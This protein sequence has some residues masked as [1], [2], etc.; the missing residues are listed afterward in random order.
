MPMRN[1]VSL[2]PR[3]PTDRSRRT[4]AA[5]AASVIAGVLLLAA[6]VP[7][8]GVGATAPSGADPTGAPTGAPRPSI[9][10]EQAVAH[11]NDKITFRAGPTVSVA[12]KPRSADHWTID[13]AAPLALPA[14]S[15]SGASIRDGQ[16]RL[17]SPAGS[18]PGTVPGRSSGPIDAP[19]VDP[20][21]SI[22]TRL[23]AVVDPG[24]LR[25]EVFGFLPYWELSDPSTTLDW[26][27]LS[28]IAYFGVGATGNGDLQQQNA[29]GSTTVGWSGWTSA[30]LT[31]VINTAHANGSRVVLTV[32]SFAWTSSQLGQQKALLGSSTA[33]ANLARQIAAAVRDRGADGVNLDFEPIAA[34]Y[35][36]E[37]TSLVQAIRGE[38]DAI[39]PGYQLTFDTMGWIGNYPIEAATAP[40]GAD[41]IVIMGYDYRT[42]S[43]GTAGSVSPLGGPNYDLNDTLAAYVQRVP[44]SKLILGVPYYG[45][46]WSTSSSALNATTVAAAKYGSSVAVLYE[47]A[48]DFST[49]YGRL[50]DPVE[51]AAWT[52]YQ[53][54]NCS[55]AYG[56]VAATRELYYDDAETLAAKYDLVNTYDI[57]GI[58]IWALGYDGSHPELY[59]VIKDKFITDTI[60]PAITGS[61][62][63]AAVF[64]PN[65]DGRQDSTTISVTVTGLIRYG[66]VV[67]PF[68]DSIA[69]APIVQGSAD[70]E[71]VAYTWDG[72][73]QDGT[74]APDGTYRVTVWTAD[75]S[76]NQ[77]SVQT[78]VT[79]DN[80]APVLTSTAKP[81][82][83]S[84]NG[85]GRSDAT[86]LGM[87]SSEPVSGVARILDKTRLVVRTWKFDPA[88]ASSWVW[89]GKD[90]AGKTVR[91][92]VY[93]LK[94]DGADPGGNRTVQ[95]LPILVDRTIGS[96]SWATSSFRP[97]LG[98]TDRVSF[99]L[100][101]PA[102][103]SV[104]IYQ[105]TTFIRRIWTDK[106]ATPGSFNWSWDGRTGHHEL[107]TPGT[108]R[109]VMTATSWIGVSTLT[110]TV[111]VKAP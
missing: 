59:Q 76:N 103:V 31:N 40:G 71:S 74:A 80:Q 10:Y 56:C 17:D 106:A 107:V 41:A 57:R 111:T 87:A 73:G 38:L 44:A 25:R 23:A 77:A 70:G 13:G 7:T 28:T 51:G 16:S 6:T 27:K 35:A 82:S 100:T 63:S 61:T 26:E 79:I 19:S 53:R 102:K 69:G 29:D 9:Q 14:G 49:Q 33:R 3:R 86:T 110:R 109:V 55:T 22:R 43:A 21:A 104:A 46:A 65:G 95:E 50:Y 37:F 81:G 62:V 67:E 42:G 89:D 2:N 91:D 75:A 58:G 85:D 5:R 12:F 64:S 99:S 48:L 66:W 15:L 78:L 72:R 34:T 108:Y 60:P 45:R 88:T 39:A 96:L 84:P 68:F 94:L 97:K 105:G 47:T 98:Q 32:Q 90:A 24:G 36:D 11:A 4:A 83:I 30:D 93:S 101:R 54:Q 52:S 1:A 8:A 18:G 20:S 92:G